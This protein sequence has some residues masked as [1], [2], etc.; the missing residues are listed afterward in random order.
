MP[1]LT[2][3]AIGWKSLAAVE[4]VYKSL[5]DPLWS[6]Y[7]DA[8]DNPPAPEEPADPPAGG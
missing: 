2:V 1:D 8:N 7:K 3:P 6:T 5:T 4:K